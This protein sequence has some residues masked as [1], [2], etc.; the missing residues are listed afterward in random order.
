MN[1]RALP[2]L[3]ARM[4]ST[5]SK[6]GSC[7]GPNPN[8]S[9][10]RSRKPASGA[11]DAHRAVALHVAVA[12]NGAGPTP[13]RPMLPRRS[14]SSIREIVNVLLLKGSIGRPGAGLCPVRGH[15][16]VQGDRTMGIWERP[17]PALLDATGREFGFDPPREHGLDVVDSIRAMRDGQVD[18]SHGHRGN[19]VTPRR[20]RPSP[21]MRWRACG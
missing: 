15:S 6:P 14:G 20:T 19:F 10:R 18:A 11:R 7:G 4:L 16:N 3:I 9:P 21:R 5:T 13:R 1:T 12:A 17:P 2:V 8:A